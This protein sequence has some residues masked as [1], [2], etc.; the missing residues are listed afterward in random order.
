MHLAAQG[1][2]FTNENIR[3]FEQDAAWFGDGDIVN[4]NFFK[5][6][7][8]FLRPPSF[9]DSDGCRGVAEA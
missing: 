7:A 3:F 5:L 2:P 6:A 4:H 9:G 8:V 1:L